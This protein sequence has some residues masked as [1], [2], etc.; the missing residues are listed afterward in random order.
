MSL[1]DGCAQETEIH[2]SRVERK[3]TKAVA[4]LV[5]LEIHCYV[6]NKQCHV[7]MIVTTGARLTR[8]EVSVVTIFG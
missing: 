3:Q 1:L 5:K 4:S 2:N 8:V 7:R 6:D